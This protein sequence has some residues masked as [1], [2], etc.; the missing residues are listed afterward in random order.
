[1]HQN[2]FVRDCLIAECTPYSRLPVLTSSID[3][4]TELTIFSIV[5]DFWW[6][7]P[8]ALAESSSR[9]HEEYDLALIPVG[10]V[11]ALGIRI[12]TP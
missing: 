3:R 7:Y 12:V 9:G 2:Q 5:F 1:M 4:S 8:R 11:Y 6:K 10:S